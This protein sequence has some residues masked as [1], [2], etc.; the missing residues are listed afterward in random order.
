MN[1]FAEL[2]KNSPRYREAIAAGGDA[3]RYFDAIGKSGYATDPNYA[4]K[5][6]QILNAGALQSAMVTRVA[7]L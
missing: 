2:L 3:K 4:D 5:L 7:K 6:N 1:D